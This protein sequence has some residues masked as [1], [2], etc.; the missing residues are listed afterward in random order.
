MAVTIHATAVVE[1]GAKLG[2]GVTVGPYCVVGP[3]V[4]LGDGVALVSHVVVAGH[5]EIGA[6]TRI[7]PFASIGHQPQDLKYRG[8]QSRLIIG[9]DNTIRESVTMNPGTEGGN[10]V[11]R[12]G[13]GGL[14]MTGTHVA[15]DCAIGDGV[16]MANNATLAGHVVIGDHAVLG[17]LCAVHQ[18]VRIGTL[19]M[20][21]GLSG[22][23][24]DVIPYGSVIGNRAWLAGLNLVGLRR[25]GIARDD[26]HALRRAYQELF[27]PEGTMTE[28]VERVAE[29][30]RDSPQVAE[31]VAFMRAKSQRGICQAKL[32]DAGAS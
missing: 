13:D 29:Q 22:V 1:P 7:F 21:G 9:R 10:M 16:I 6:G 32:E 31:V 18:F 11:T 17:G 25:R 19:A 5:T 26:I 27:A 4:V 28:R 24:F 8:E 15:H 2:E 30:Y 14:F 23:E 20:V 12:V 3:D